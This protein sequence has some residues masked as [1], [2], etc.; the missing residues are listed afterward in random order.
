MQVNRKVKRG[1]RSQNVCNPLAEFASSDQR[2]WRSCHCLWGTCYLNDRHF[3]VA[4]KPPVAETSQPGPAPVAAVPAMSTTSWAPST[5]PVDFL[6]CL[7]RRSSQLANE[8]SEK[9]MITKIVATT[10]KEAMVLAP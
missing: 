1:A 3:P 5:A 7:S 10:V 9:L 6:P 4:P 2:Q 8:V